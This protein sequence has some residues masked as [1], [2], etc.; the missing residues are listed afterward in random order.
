MKTPKPKT[1]HGGAR[2]GAGRPIS[3]NRTSSIRLLI[4]QADHLTLAEHPDGYRLA[5]EA[6]IK[7][8]ASLRPPPP[9]A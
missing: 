7:V 9:S 4:P 1:A 3:P 2:T 5:K 6:V 8:A